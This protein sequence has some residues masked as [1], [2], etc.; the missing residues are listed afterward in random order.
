MSFD[1]RFNPHRVRKAGLPSTPYA[2]ALKAL[3][4][5]ARPRKDFQRVFGRGLEEYLL[6]HGYITCEEGRYYLTAA[7][8]SVLAEC[9]YPPVP[10]EIPNLEEA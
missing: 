8:V 2:K 1:F 5:Y 3:W 10:E 7:G 9:G 4:N 6:S